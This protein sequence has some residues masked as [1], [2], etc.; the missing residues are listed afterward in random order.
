L[1]V[2]KMVVHLWIKFITIGAKGQT[3]IRI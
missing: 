2:N 1:L 3:T